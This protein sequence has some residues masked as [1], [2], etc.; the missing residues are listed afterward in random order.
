[1]CLLPC[2]STVSKL[3][4]IYLSDPIAA[5]YL[6]MLQMPPKKPG[7]LPRRAACVII[8]EETIA[9]ALTSAASAEAITDAVM[10]QIWSA[11]ISH[12]SVLALEPSLSHAVILQ[13][14]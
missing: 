9:A 7:K 4:Y 10:L 5:V 6:T 14:S 8:S 13:D 2:I 3:Q 11:T 1:M 12:R